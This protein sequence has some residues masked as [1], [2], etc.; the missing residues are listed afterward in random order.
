MSTNEA[1]PAGQE[2]RKIQVSIRALWKSFGKKDILKGI[3]LDV[4]DRE[5]VVILGPSGSGKS[6][7]LR[8]VNWLEIPTSGQITI[9]GETVTD[10]TN[11]NNI[12][13]EVGM[14]FQRFNLFPHMNVLKNITLAPM[15]VKGVSREEAEETAMKLLK[16]V[17]LADRAD[18]MPSELSGGQQQRVAIA[19]ALAMSPKIM[20]FDEPTSALD[21]EMV[22]EVLD[23][24]KSLAEEGMT[25]MCVTHEMGF[26]RQVADRVIFVDD[27]K[28]LEQGAP[29]EIFSH[30][31]EQRTKDFFSKIL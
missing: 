5:V 30:P 3:D 24:M 21:P 11:L 8:C 2:K 19:R 1:A 28:I 4:A 7:L 17:G 6:T 26:A 12:R 14:V 23:V 25:M 9:S 27:G 18:A 15:K 16:R 13:A 10:K 29:E 31:K 20:L 22:N